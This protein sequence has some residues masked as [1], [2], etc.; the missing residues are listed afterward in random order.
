MTK[1]KK[2]S[3]KQNE[4]ENENKNEIKDKQPGSRSSKC[5]WSRTLLD[6]EKERAEYS[7]TETPV[8]LATLAV[9]HMMMILKVCV[10]KEEE[11]DEDNSL[12]KAVKLADTQKHTRSAGTGTMGV[13]HCNICCISVGEDTLAN[14]MHKVAM[15]LCLAEVAVTPW[16]RCCTV[17]HKQPDNCHHIYFNVQS[18]CVL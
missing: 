13:E 6:W 1:A 7:E 9:V 16:H 11:E 15:T 14:T 12:E 8:E 2:E 3:K 17:Y 18:G 10:D 4:N 5:H